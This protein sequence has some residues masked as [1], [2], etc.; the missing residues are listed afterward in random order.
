MQFLTQCNTILFHGLP[1]CILRTQKIK[2]EEEGVHRGDLKVQVEV[3]VGDLL[4]GCLLAE[5]PQE[6]K[7][8][9]LQQQVEEGETSLSGELLESQPGK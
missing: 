9:S 5:D 3:P 8:H 1:C 6:E 7:H 4:A 2:E